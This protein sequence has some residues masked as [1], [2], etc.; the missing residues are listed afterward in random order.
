MIVLG[1]LAGIGQF[2]FQWFSLLSSYDEQQM[3]I[4]G[5]EI[6]VELINRVIA[7]HNSYAQ[8]STT[9]TEEI[10]KFLGFEPLYPPIDRSL[11][12]ETEATVFIYPDYLRIS[13]TYQ[14]TQQEQLY[15]RISYYN[16]YK[17]AIY[18]FEQNTTGI[19]RIIRGTTLYESVNYSQK[20]LSWISN[21][22]II[23]IYGNNIESSVLYRLAENMIGGQY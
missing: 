16:D 17:N 12:E 15:Y 5:H 7:E 10:T 19:E 21:N 6:S 11:W 18:S 14:S 4:T 2:K 9:T 8:L 20:A 22:V 13:C 3:V 1:V 23:S